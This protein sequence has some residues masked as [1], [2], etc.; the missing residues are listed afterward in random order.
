MFSSQK[1]L[2]FAIM[3]DHIHFENFI[4]PIKLSLHL[5]S[6]DIA[7]GIRSS[8]CHILKNATLPHCNLASVEK[9]HALISLRRKKH[10]ILSADKSRSTVI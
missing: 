1:G 8:I 4:T 9:K 7:N 3:P 5:L 6:P 10:L 2:N